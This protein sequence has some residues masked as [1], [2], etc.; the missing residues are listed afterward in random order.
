[1]QAFTTVP[2]QGRYIWLPKPWEYVREKL[3][4]PRL[5]NDSLKFLKVAATLDSK[6]VVETE[7][8]DE[9]MA[10]CKVDHRFWYNAAHLVTGEELKGYSVALVFQ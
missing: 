9:V 10:R 2:K 4:K 6:Q 5:Y 8:G 3:I 1:M 7:L